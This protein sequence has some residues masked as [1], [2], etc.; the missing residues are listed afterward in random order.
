M[1]MQCPGQLWEG[2]EENISSLNA[3]RQTLYNFIYREDELFV[4]L[5]SLLEVLCT[6]ENVTPKVIENMTHCCRL[7]AAFSE[8]LQ[9]D[10]EN[11]A[12]NRL[13]FILQSNHEA[14]WVIDSNWRA[15]GDD[16]QSCMRL[17]YHVKRQ[18]AKQTK[19]QT[20]S[21]LLD[22]ESSLVLA[23]T[24]AAGDKGKWFINFNGK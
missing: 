16:Q 11:A 18:Q 20:M 2:L 4:D 24:S 5:P 3:V 15:D 19:T 1:V 17:E 6:L 13:L 21:Q 14:H 10:S 22:F 9:S 7:L 8:L 23:Q 12:P